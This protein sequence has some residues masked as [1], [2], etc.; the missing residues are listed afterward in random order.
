MR[1]SKRQ[2]ILNSA[3]LYSLMLFAC[4]LAS[5][6]AVR[7]PNLKVQF[8]NAST[9]WIVGSRLLMTKDGGK[10]WTELR[11]NGLGTVEAEDIFHGQ[12]WIQFTSPETGWSVGGSGVARTTDG[13]RTWTS[14]VVTDG[15]DQSLQSLFFISPYEGWVVGADVY[16]TSDGGQNWGKLSETPRGDV[17]RQR[18]MR[19]APSYAIYKP[20]LWFTDT[21]NGFMAR[22]DGEVYRTE[23]GGRTWK[24]IWRVDRPL[25]DIF[26]F[27]GQDGWIVGDGGLVVRTIDGGRAWTPTPTPTN[28]NLTSIFFIDKQVG[29]AVGYGGTILYTRDGGGTWKT[30][31]TNGLWLPSPLAS[32]SFSDELHGW[33]VGGNNDPMTPSLTSPS[34]I[35]LTTEDGGQTWR[36]VQP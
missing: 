32:V 31:A 8:V 10:T 25:T 19:V 11:H 20:A 33:A 34:N 6:T 24:M 17:Q 5:C 9:G 18:S 23:D 7:F 29:C 14:I 16:H 26:F 2:S 21:R 1:A 28:A 4:L 30:A 35:I 12:H 27:N 13:G 36:A 15:E 3:L 22:L